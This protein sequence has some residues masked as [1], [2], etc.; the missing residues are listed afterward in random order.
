[1]DAVLL[2]TDV[3]SYLLRTG[4]RRGESY[5]KH[6]QGK[7]VAVSFITVGE[8]YYGASKRGWSSKTVAALEQRL[9]AAVIVPYD[10]EIC[11]TYGKLRAALRT[12]SGSHRVLQNDLWIAA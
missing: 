1:M 2:D 5:Q 9:K 3:F 7:T 12:E 10:I 11:R 6:V 4:D 8:L